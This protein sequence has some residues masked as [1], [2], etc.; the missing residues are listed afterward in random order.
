MYVVPS[1]RIQL[2]TT[3]LTES[4]KGGGD[5]E[6]AIGDLGLAQTGEFK[7]CTKAPGGL[8]PGGGSKAVTLMSMM[9]SLEALKAERVDTYFLHAY[10][11]A[12]PL[13]ET[14]DAVQELY[15]A[16]AF[17]RFGLSNFP[18]SAVVELHEYAKSRPGYVLPTVYQ[19][20]YSLASR[21]CESELFPVLRR[22]GIAIQ[23]YSPTAGE[24]P[25]RL[26]D[27]LS[28]T[29]RLDAERSNVCKLHHLTHNKPVF[30]RFLA[31]YSELVRESGVGR[32]E[33]AYRWIVW[34]SALRGGDAIVMDVT[35]VE[36]AREA[37]AAVRK[38]PLEPWVVQRLEDMWC[39]VAADAMLHSLEATTSVTA[40]EAS[41][42]F[43]KTV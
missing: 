2:I 26:A 43:Q 4:R 11:A 22:L 29:R 25:V 12:T 35:S 8:V 34:N 14:M 9:H 41:Q 33:L 16:G 27:S 15:Q 5:S 28:G 18:T 31:A 6:K 10:D 23:A 38:G 7:I 20:P 24:P 42:M 40:E 1:R 37:L 30:V 19:A 39:S 32:A 3:V 17:A 21:G 13:S 36:Q